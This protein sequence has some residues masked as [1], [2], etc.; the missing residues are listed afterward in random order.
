[1]WVVCLTARLNAADIWDA[2]VFS[3]TPEALRQAADAVKP[4]KDNEATVL[5]NEERFTRAAC[6]VYDAGDLLTMVRR[7]RKIQ[8]RR[9]RR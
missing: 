4:G 2:P 8:I 1:M 6:P 5:L 9:L 7:H 3:A